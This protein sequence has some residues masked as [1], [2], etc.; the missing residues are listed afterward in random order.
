MAATQTNAQR[1]YSSLLRF[2]ASLLLPLLLVTEALCGEILSFLTWILGNW[3]QARQGILSPN[4]HVPREFQDPSWTS[5]NPCL[6]SDTQ[7]LL[8]APLSL[9]S[10][11]WSC[12]HVMASL[13]KIE[14]KKFNN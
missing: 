6:G 13:P 11:G 1:C 10:S 3:G 4:S 9:G 5:Q 2:A 8:E 14:V 7:V 12:V